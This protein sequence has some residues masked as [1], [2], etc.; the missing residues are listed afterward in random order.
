MEHLKRLPKL[1]PEKAK[2]ELAKRHFY[3]FLVEFWDVIIPDKFVD[4]WHITYLC[5]E[6][7]KVALLVF[8]R[9][10]KKHDLIINIP[11]GTSKSTICTVVFPV[12]CWVND[13]AI[14]VITGS[15][16]SDL[17]TAHSVKS[18]DIVRSDK[19]RRWYPHIELKAD[20]DNKTNY[21]NLQGGERI[22]TS[23]GGT[24]TGKHAH[25]IVV[26][27][28][29][30]AEQAA[31]LADRDRAN[32]WM[33]QTLST[34]KVD[35]EMTPT[36]LVMQRL[37]VDD[38]T[39]HMLARKAE[40][41][42]HICLPGELA[43]NV[44]PEELKEKYNN[45]LLDEK[46]LNRTVLDEQKKDLGSYGYAGQIG[47]TPV[48]EGGVIWQKW[49][50]PVPD[51]VFPAPEDLTNYGTDWDTAYTD[52]EKNDASAYCTSGMADK[53]IY[54]DRVGFKK[55]EFP[56]L[57]RYM[58][59]RSAPHYIEAKASGKSAKQ[60]LKQ[61]GISAIEVQVIGGDKVARTSF[62]TPMA[63]AGLV[64]VRESILDMIYN[65]TEQGLLHFP[66]GLH[67]DLNDAIVQALQRHSKPKANWEIF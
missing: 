63:E 43:N 30:N 32:R 52:K 4:N 61:N 59:L 65:D 33:T 58:T 15:Y 45:G 28:P 42:K 51:K 39:G 40:S 13:P 21:Q 50:I 37:H 9:Q 67:D 27:D 41:I 23:V 55:L 64:Y 44:R 20:M 16:S 24:I 19:F 66:N 1:D 26:D 60:T 54:L 18:R 22:A 6:L 38:C 7:Q 8:D 36:I 12:W 47:Q 46:R 31:S 25:I 56:Q 17:S 10:P 11:P 57:I 48:P 35:K 62:A 29:L 53:K 3:R 2:A 14:R 49:F 5:E 34:R